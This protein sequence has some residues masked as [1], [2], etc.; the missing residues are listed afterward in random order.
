MAQDSTEDLQLGLSLLLALVVETGSGFGLYLACG[1]WQRQQQ[2]EGK[3]V[4]PNEPKRLGTVDECAL[5]RLQPSPGGTISSATFYTD[6]TAWCRQTG[7]VA[8]ASEPFFAGF[9]ALG[10]EVGMRVTTGQGK[11][12]YEDVSLGRSPA[13]GV[14]S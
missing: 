11:S 1:L 14:A 9:N 8:L 12:V 2:E 7:A 10:S 3:Q 6:Y 4:A 13:E 5:A